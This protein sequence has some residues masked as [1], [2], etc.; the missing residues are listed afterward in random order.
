MA[1]SSQYVTLLQTTQRALPFGEGEEGSQHQLMFGQQVVFE[2][3]CSPVV[4]QFTSTVNA[5]NLLREPS[6]FEAKLAIQK[7]LFKSKSAEGGLF[8]LAIHNITAASLPN[9]PNYRAGRGS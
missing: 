8:L 2:T 5:N 9:W 6:R 4:T 1:N 3:R 7:T